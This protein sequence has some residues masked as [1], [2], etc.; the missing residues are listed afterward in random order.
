M[1]YTDNSKKQGNKSKTIISKPL[2]EGCKGCCFKLPNDCN[3]RYALHAGKSC[4][5]PTSVIFI[6]VSE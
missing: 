1:T 5:V 4:E 2:T 6:E 3:K